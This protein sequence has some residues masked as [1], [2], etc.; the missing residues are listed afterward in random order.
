M[1]PA[2]TSG[3]GGGQRQ[4][5]AAP[6]LPSFLGIG[7]PRAG[8][9][10]LHDLLASHPQVRMPTLRKELNFFGRNYERGL[11]WYLS[12]F[13]EPSV[14]P[15]RAIGE[16]TPMYMYQEECLE[17]VRSLGSVE[18]FIVCLRDPVDLLWSHYRQQAAIHDFR[19]SLAEFMD[20]RPDA[21]A[22]GL[23]ARALRPWFDAFGLDRFLLLRFDEMTADVGRTEALLGSFL[24]IDPALFPPSAGT[25]PV[26]RSFSPRYRRAYRVA[27]RVADSLHRTDRSWIVDVAKRVGLAGALQRE[28][29]AANGPSAAQREAVRTLYRHDLV[30]LARLTGHDL[31]PWIHGP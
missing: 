31:R 23:Y 25:Q 30:E 19:G 24:G 12:C 4:A 2:V 18:R 28:R 26:N 3:A 22:N 21:V 7:A 27:K 10:W 6:L 17:R 13:G 8:T 1:R 29:A 15:P 9:T 20:T 5:T 14:P 16:I 11:D